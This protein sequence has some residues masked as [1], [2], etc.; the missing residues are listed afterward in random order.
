MTA[1]EDQLQDQLQETIECIRRAG[2]KLWVLTGDKVETAIEIGYASK[3]LSPSMKLIV[4]ETADEL[5]A[6]PQPQD[7]TQTYGLVLT[8]HSLIDIL[9]SNELKTKIMR[10]AEHC[11]SV[12]CCRVSPSQKKDV[13]NLVKEAKPHVS[14]LAIGDGANDVSM[15]TAAHVGVGIQGVEGKQASRA[16]DYAIGEFK[17]LRGLLFLYGRECYRRNA[18][19]ILYNFY[20]NIVLV[21]PQFW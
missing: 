1:I 3:L 8:G 19:T 18:N 15:I 17:I 16:S 21:F 6:Q 11:E 10:I 5:A 14:T 7:P 9:N 20:K 13:V 12:V 2:I 4:I